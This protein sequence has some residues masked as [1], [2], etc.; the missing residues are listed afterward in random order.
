MNAV[1]G[2]VVLG[3]KSAK[4]SQISSCTMSKEKEKEGRA[5]YDLV[6]PY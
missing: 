6:P 5:L 3:V 1:H 4:S 2:G